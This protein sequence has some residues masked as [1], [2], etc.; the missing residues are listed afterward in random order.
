MWQKVS[1]KKGTQEYPETERTNQGVPEHIRPLIVRRLAC[2][3][4]PSEVR[5]YLME[6]H[7]VD[8]SAWTIGRHDPTNKGSEGYLR[9][10]LVDLFKSKGLEIYTPD[11]EAFRKFAQEKYLASDLAKDWPAGMVDKINAL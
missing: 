10:E 5:A 3:D 7:E 6:E 1:N 9:K 8:I 4:R 2:Y 11:V